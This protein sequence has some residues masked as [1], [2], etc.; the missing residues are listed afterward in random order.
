MNKIPAKKVILREDVVGNE[1]I[2]TERILSSHATIE[3]HLY[4]VVK[5]IGQVK[6]GGHKH[7]VEYIGLIQK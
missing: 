7:E 2:T 6:G 4:K 1:M 3:G 5:Y